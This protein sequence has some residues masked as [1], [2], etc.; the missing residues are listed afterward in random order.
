MARVVPLIPGAEL[1][2]GM[3]ISRVF[4]AES[5]PPTRQWSLDCW[6]VRLTGN[7]RCGAFSVVRATYT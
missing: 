1:T 4:H 7:R 3:V 5:D 6:R 2:S